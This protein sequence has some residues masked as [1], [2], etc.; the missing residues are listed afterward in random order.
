MTKNPVEQKGILIH[1]AQNDNCLS[2]HEP[3]RCRGGEFTDRR[4]VT[5]PGEKDGQSDEES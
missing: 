3:A 1:C 5:C 4:E 2:F